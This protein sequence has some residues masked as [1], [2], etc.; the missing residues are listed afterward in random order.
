MPRSNRIVLLSLVVLALALLWLP[1]GERLYVVCP[2]HRLTGWDCPFCGGQRMMHHLLCGR[3][4]RAFA[5]NPL[6]F[7]FLPVGALWLLRQCCPGLCR[8]HPRLA[9]DRLFTP[10]A[11]WIYVAL[12]LIWGLVRNLLIRDS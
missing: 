6:L 9:A 10:R 3:V 2:L 11:G 8:R 12:F 7:L 5:C 4:A 1:G